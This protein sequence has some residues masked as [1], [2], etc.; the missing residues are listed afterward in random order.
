MKSPILF[1]DNNM[2]GI[3]ISVKLSGVVP[4]QSLAMWLNQVFFAAVL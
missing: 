4:Q 3:S 1:S 2:V